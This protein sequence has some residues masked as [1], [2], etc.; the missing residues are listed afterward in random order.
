[1]KS[2][3]FQC[4]LMTVLNFSIFISLGEAAILGEIPQQKLL[5]P[6][7]Q[8]QPAITQQ[9]QTFRIKPSNLEVHLGEEVVLRCEIDHRAGQVQWTKDGFALGFTDEIVGFPRYSLNQ[10]HNDGVYNLRI[11]NASFDDSA[12]YQCQV[13]PTKGIKPI[14]AGAKVTVLGSTKAHHGIHHRN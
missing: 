11:T 6:K 8:Q 2:P 1:M 4:L 9:Q 3:G 13:G 10:N 7:E 14:R 12:D 5:H